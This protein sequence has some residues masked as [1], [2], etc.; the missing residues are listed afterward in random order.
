MPCGPTA[1]H[2]QPR[3]PEGISFTNPESPRR[4][5]LGNESGIIPRLCP[6]VGNES[7]IIPQLC[8]KVGNDIP[9]ITHFT[10]DNHAKTMNDVPPETYKTLYNKKTA[11]N[12]GAV[13][14]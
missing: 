3:R 10:K 2:K 5:K 14:K 8:P 4:T 7:D 12:E 6:K 11:Q 13:E 1:V 9:F